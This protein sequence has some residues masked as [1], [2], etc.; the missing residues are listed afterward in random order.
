VTPVSYKRRF[1]TGAVVGATP[2]WDETESSKLLSSEQAGE[3]VDLK[4]DLKGD[5]KGEGVMGVMAAVATVVEEDA[6][7][8]GL[9]GRCGVT[10]TAE[11]SGSAA[12]AVMMLRWWKFSCS[13]EMSFPSSSLLSMVDDREEL[14]EDEVKVDKRRLK[15]VDAILYCFAERILEPRFLLPN[16]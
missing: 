2:G 7:F 3:G 8:S 9:G 16:E 4:G 6:I 13:V 5:A 14:G 1:G 11:P 10:T 12:M 15:L